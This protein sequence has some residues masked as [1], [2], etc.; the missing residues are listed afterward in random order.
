MPNL[1]TNVLFFSV[2]SKV[3]NALLYVFCSFQNHRNDY[4]MPFH[5]PFESHSTFVTFVARF[6]SK[7]ISTAAYVV[8]GS[9]EYR[10]LKIARLFY[11]WIFQSIT[12]F[13]KRELSKIVSRHTM[14]SVSAYICCGLDCLLN[15]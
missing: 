6:D 12:P 3:F 5:K 9:I 7:M 10:Y 13:G 4:N 1:S 8:S 2:L 14:F 11:L 15:F